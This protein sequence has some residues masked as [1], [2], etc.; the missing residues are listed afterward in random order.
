MLERNDYISWDE[1]FMGIAQTIALRSKDPATQ[2]GA[3]IVD[4]TN[5]VL[6]LGYNGAPNGY[7][8][9]MFPWGKVGDE[10]NTK[11]PYV[12]H[13]EMNAISNFNG[14]KQLLNGAKV[15][16]TLFPCNE[17]AKLIIQNGIKEVIYAENKHQDSNSVIASKTMLRM[18]GVAIRQFDYPL[19]I[20]LNT[21]KEDNVKVRKLTNSQENV[22]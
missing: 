6:S 2:V 14:N 7:N 9:K 22:K 13:A 18:C 3:V 16:V 20:K 11:Y 10:L 1:A 21:S 8:D 12:C 15:Y 19:D 5:H 4:Q 17:C